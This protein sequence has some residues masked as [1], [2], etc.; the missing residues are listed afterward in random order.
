MST[1]LVQYVYNFSL[2]LAHIVLPTMNDSFGNKS[3]VRGKR[4]AQ[5]S[6]VIELPMAIIFSEINYLRTRKR[7]HKYK[8]SVRKLNLHS[9]TRPHMSKR[10]WV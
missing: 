2:V 8:L 6:D 5:W 3:S 4:H 10:N 7:D 1:F 9:P